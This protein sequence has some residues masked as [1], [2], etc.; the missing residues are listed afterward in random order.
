MDYGMGNLL[1][2]KKK[3]TSLNYHALI[4]SDPDEILNAEKIILPGVGHFKKA[5]DI[6]HLLGLFDALNTAVLE[7]KAPIMGI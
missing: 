5:M 2:V 7:K 1:S 3:I 4:S 6:I